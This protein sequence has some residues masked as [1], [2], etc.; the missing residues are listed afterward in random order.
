MGKYIKFIFTTKLCNWIVYMYFYEYE[1]Y[2]QEH[3]SHIRIFYCD[4]G[5]TAKKLSRNV[6]LS[7]LTATSIT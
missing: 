4:E 6:P 5:C 1:I 7:V 3:T 2:L